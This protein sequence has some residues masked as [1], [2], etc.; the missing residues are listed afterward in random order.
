MNPTVEWTIMILKHL[1]QTGYTGKIEVNSNQGSV[2]G[3]NLSQ[4]IKPLQEIRIIPIGREVA[5]SV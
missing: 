5:V 1:S 3:L 2:T 4:S